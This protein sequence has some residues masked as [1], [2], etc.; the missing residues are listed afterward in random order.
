MQRGHTLHALLA[1]AISVTSLPNTEAVGPWGNPQR[2]REGEREACSAVFQY[3]L[4]GGKEIR[5]S[6]G[7]RGRRAALCS[8]VKIFHVWC[9]LLDG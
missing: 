7:N 2:R 1:H 6:Y 4:A 9:S 3:G 8:A 5:Q